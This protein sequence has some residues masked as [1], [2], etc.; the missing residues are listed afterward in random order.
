MGQYQF[1]KI[2]TICRYIYF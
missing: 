2:N 1:L